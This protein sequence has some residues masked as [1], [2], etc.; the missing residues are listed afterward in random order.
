MAQDGNNE[1]KLEFTPEGET[2]GY[3]SLDQARV[4]T[5][6][7]TDTPQPNGA[8][9]PGGHASIVL[10]LSASYISAGDKEICC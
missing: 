7:T 8:A 9:A 1:D 2:P 5:T 6:H 10:F 3:I 4:L